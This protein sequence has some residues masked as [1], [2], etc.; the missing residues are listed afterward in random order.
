Q[1][2]ADEMIWLLE[3][4]RVLFRS[5]VA[6]LLLVPVPEQR[7]PVLEVA[8]VAQRILLRF[9]LP[10]RDPLGHR[11]D[12]PPELVDVRGGSGGGHA[13]SGDRKSVVLGGRADRGCRCMS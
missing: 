10:G 12:P 8:P 2:T 9:E 13:L 6:P 4:R 1:M 7:A 11:G 5:G 3:F